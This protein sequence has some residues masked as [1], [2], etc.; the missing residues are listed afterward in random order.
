M[1]TSRPKTSPSTDQA[2]P[3]SPAP[4]QTASLTADLVGSGR[5]LIVG[6]D[7][8]GSATQT[9]RYRAQLEE[10]TGLEVVVIPGC[11]SLAVV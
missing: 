11:T 1:T 7:R 3:A 9:E 6:I 5:V 10:K 4:E 2:D 8:T